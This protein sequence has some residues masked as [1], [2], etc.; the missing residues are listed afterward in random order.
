MEQETNITNINVASRLELCNK[1]KSGM[2]PPKKE[3]EP[4][5]TSPSHPNIELV[6]NIQTMNKMDNKYPT[7]QLTNT[8]RILST[9]LLKGQKS[10]RSQNSKS[11]IRYQLKRSCKGTTK[12]RNTGINLSTSISSRNIG[13]CSYSHTMK[14]NNTSAK[15]KIPLPEKVYPP[16]K[17][18][19]YTKSAGKKYPINKTM[20]AENLN[21]KPKNIKKKHKRL[22]DNLLLEE[23]KLINTKIYGNEDKNENISEEQIKLDK[24]KLETE[25]FLH[26]LEDRSKSR[27]CRR[28]KRNKNSGS[29]IRI[30]ERIIPKTSMGIYIRDDQRKEMQ[31]RNP[32]RGVTRNSL[33]LYMMTKKCLSKMN[34][35]VRSP[36]SNKYNLEVFGD[37]V[38]SSG[39]KDLSKS[40]SCRN[41]LCRTTANPIKYVKVFGPMSKIYKLSPKY[42]PKPIIFPLT[43][44]KITPSLL[45]FNR[46]S[47]IMSANSRP[48]TRDEGW[49]KEISG[50]YN[51]LNLSSTDGKTLLRDKTSENVRNGEELKVKGGII[52]GKEGWEV[53]GDTRVARG[54]SSG[55]IR[56][57]KR[58]TG[59]SITLTMD[60]FHPINKNIDVIL[61][62]YIY[63]FRYLI[64]DISS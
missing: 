45:K 29:I 24:Y 33:N 25:E 49:K 35:G 55:R 6:E 12:T 34:S 58:N 31:E 18:D 44:A 5:A 36:V 60:N 28:V 15:L 32:W 57:A 46:N 63:I 54:L 2:S 30:C 17:S 39:N 48:C 40:N 7:P 20:E 11:K 42:S 13:F 3:K 53:K 61:Y 9:S 14:R 43:Q 8:S 4:S 1:F 26:S 41:L 37:T 64:Y 38:K 52:K 47:N 22:F 21:N 50:N 16:I 10:N 27:S 23:A 19:K 59:Y 56:N 51:L 62:I